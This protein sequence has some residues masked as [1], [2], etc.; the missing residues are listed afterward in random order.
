LQPKLDIPRPPPYVNGNPWC[1]EA[2]VIVVGSGAGG[3]TVASE[4][5]KGGFSVIVL[6]KGPYFRAD[7]FQQWTEG[8][9]LSSTM[10][11]G[12]LLASKDNNIAVLS[13]S[14]VGGGTTINWS[15]SFKLPSPVQREWYEL[16]LHQFREGGEYELAYHHICKLANVNSR[17]SYSDESTVH[18]GDDEH[19]IV[20]NGN[21]ALWNAAKKC[22]FTPEKIPR[23]VKD[24]VD[25]GNCC[26]GCPYNSKQSTQTALLEPLQAEAK[27]RLVVIPHVTVSRIVIEN[28]VAI[29]AEGVLTEYL[30]DLLPYY[31]R[32]KVTRSISVRGKIVVAACGAIQT[33]ALLLRSGLTHPLIGKHLTLH[34]VVGTGGIVDDSNFDCQMSK[35]VCMG[36]VVK[37]PTFIA[38]TEKSHG[39]AIET[40]PVHPGIFALATPWDNG[41]SYKLTMLN[42]FNKFVTYIGISR[43]HSTASNCVTI[44]K[45]GN[46]IIN[47]VLTSQDENILIHGLIENLK[48]MRKSGVRVLN[49]SYEHLPMYTVP[50]NDDTPEADVAFEK[51][52]DNIRKIG[53]KP[54]QAMLF[55]AHQMSSCRMATSSQNGP[56]NPEGEL[57][58]TR[59]LFIADASV[60]PTSLGINPMITVQSMALMISKNIIRKLGKETTPYLGCNNKQNEIKDW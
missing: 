10:D 28:G 12:A 25:C 16:G 8:E 17:F 51:Y 56:V 21:K 33:P 48:L 49:A 15:A 53:I 40:P 55:S 47:Y 1:L 46:A 36:V 37:G 31:E 54:H 42:S 3:G 20:N 43:D 34:P 32:A 4:L 52:C 50:I 29:G 58:E 59:N 23:N 39:V 22:G 6:E 38:P 27:G 2:D 14:C 5:V 9:A 18:D 19:F 24:C 44:D 11:K 7:T 30:G 13:G 35:G 41:L 26:F 45:N 57:Y 60:F